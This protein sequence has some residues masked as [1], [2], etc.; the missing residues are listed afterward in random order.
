MENKILKQEK[1]HQSL[2]VKMVILAFMG[3][4]LL[5]PLQ[6]I[7][8]VIRERAQ[9]ADEARIEIGKL[10]STSQII[11][12]PVLNVPGKKIVSEKGDFV[13]TT[14]H[15]LPEKLTVAGNISPEK[16][17]RGIYEAVVY[18]SEIKM[19]GNFSIK[20]YES[21]DDF[22][23]DWDDA[24]I[25]L[26]VSD[27]KGIRDNVTLDIDGNVIEAEPGTPDSDVFDK[28]ITL[29]LRQKYVINDNFKGSFTIKMG[30]RGSECLS[31]SPVGKTTEVA[32][33]S[34]WNAPS[35]QGT[36]LPVDSKVTQD[37][38][39]AKWVVT[40]LNRNFPQAWT[41]AKYKP[42]TAA[43][44]VNLMLEIDHYKKAERSAKY[45]LLFILFT[46]FVLILVE[47]RSSEKIQVFYYLL[48]AFALIL[49]FSLLSALSEQI[50]FN[51]AYLVSSASVIGLLS[52]FFRSLLKKGWVVLLI[53]GL[54][55]VLYL[56]IFILLAMKDYAYLGG[57]IGLFILLAILMLYSSRY[58]LFSENRA[59]VDDK[60]A[61]EH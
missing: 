24:Y 37:G 10:W 14:M 36:F 2:T 61:V 46:F 54:L 32:I 44:G 22:I 35:F 9:Y 57:N 38:F 23:Y 55:T 34:G 33:S 5:I 3:L 25:T 43:F 6:M 7:K 53:S 47:F 4:L 17:H 12:G 26:G 39:K 16:R 60:N 1:W 41:G 18:D 19:T 11:T 50:G 31:F 58:K 59:E 56:F 28:G 8:E 49:F 40:H 15:I 45:G 48:V 52:L 42:E 21:L 29:P 51:A 20:G 13:T 30:L 27:N